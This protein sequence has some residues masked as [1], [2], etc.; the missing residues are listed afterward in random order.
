MHMRFSD[1]FVVVTGAAGGIGLA[2]ATAFAQEGARVAVTDVSPELLATAIAQIESASGTEVLG[3]TGDVSNAED[4]AKNVDAILSEF[5]HIDVLVNNA[6]IIRRAPSEEMAIDDWRKVLSINLDGTFYWSQQVAAKS[7]IPRRSGAIVNVASISGMVGFPNTAPYVASKHGVVGLTKALAIDWAQY[8]IRVNAICP[9][10]TWTNISNAEV[11]R[12]P[13]HFIDR[14]PRIPLG[15]AAQPEEQ[16]AAI[17]FLASEA[18]SHVDGLIMNVD[19]GQVALSSG[20]VT[21]RS[22]SSA[23]R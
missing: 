9:G 8:G 10:M 7:M 3:L 20:H 19:G 15:H 16:A 5:D 4:V 18:A 13:N 1:Q 12:N 14:E 21:P 6:G 23:K 2:A 22:G 17:L 11:A